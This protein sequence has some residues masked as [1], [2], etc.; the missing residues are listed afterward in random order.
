M[1]CSRGRC[2]PEL[3]Q[4]RGPGLFF[5]LDPS[6]MG[7][8][9]VHAGVARAGPSLWEVRRHSFSGFYERSM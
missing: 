5:L 2:F 7:G 8:G 1:I 3:G 6:T 4:G 9:E